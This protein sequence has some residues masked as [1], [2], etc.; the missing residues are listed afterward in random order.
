MF[1]LKSKNNKKGDDLSIAL[2]RNRKHGEDEVMDKTT[3][4]NFHVR[5]LLKRRVWIWETSKNWFKWIRIKITFEN[6]SK[7]FYAKS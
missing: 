1:H 6:F 7:F 3:K 2:N 4:E 5:V